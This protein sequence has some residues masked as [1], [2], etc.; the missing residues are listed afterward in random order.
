V[1]RMDRMFTNS[2]FNGDISEWTN[3]PD[4]YQEIRKRYRARLEQEPKL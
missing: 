4:C 3:K 2:Q 1:T